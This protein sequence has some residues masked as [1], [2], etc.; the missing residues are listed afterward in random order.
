MQKPLFRVDEMAGADGSEQGRNGSRFTASFKFVKRIRT[1][2]A[3][4]KT[5]C[6][7]A[8]MAFGGVADLHSDQ[9]ASCTFTTI[10][11][12]VTLMQEAIGCAPRAARASWGGHDQ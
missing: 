2:R 4:R 10:A 9:T 8:F 11:W 5:V 12:P 6:N 1:D 3:A 7:T